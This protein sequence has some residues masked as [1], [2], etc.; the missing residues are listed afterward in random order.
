MN[1]S[2]TVTD[3]LMTVE[4]QYGVAWNM[5]LSGGCRSG[6]GLEKYRTAWH[7]GW[8]VIVARARTAEVAN[9]TLWWLR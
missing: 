8:W 3:T 4:D 1:R 9:L 6:L 7:L 5:G 2:R